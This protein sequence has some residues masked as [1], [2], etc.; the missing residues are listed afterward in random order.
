MG[1]FDGLFGPSHEQRQVRKLSKFYGG[2]AQQNLPA[3]IDELWKIINSQGLTPG[4]Q[5][6][7]S[8]FDT[9]LEGGYQRILSDLLGT[10][11]ERGM[12]NSLLDMGTRAA[13]GRSYASDKAR[14]AG[15]L[16]GMSEEQRRQAL[17]MLLQL[18]SGAGQTAMGGYQGADQMG[19]S[20]VDLLGAAGGFGGG[21]ADILNI[22]KKK[23]K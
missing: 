10:N 17:Q 15:G 1:L 9:D 14:Y 8:I 19:T 11:K 13:A 22:F 5:A 12:G 21:L 6:Q 23:P 20:F 2:I 18:S 4:A 7:K 3:G 16:M